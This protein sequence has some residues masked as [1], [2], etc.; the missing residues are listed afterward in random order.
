MHVNKIRNNFL[1]FRA[2]I[3]KD[4]SETQEKQTSTN[5]K[6]LLSLAAL[7]TIG[8]SVVGAKKTAKI[9]F[10]EALKNNGVEIKNGIAILIESGE[11][12]TGKIQRFE[13]GNRKETVEYTDGL[14]K[15]KVY[16]NLFGREL[17][18]EFYR[19]GVLKVR[20]NPYVI[21]DGE[22]TFA[23][24]DNGGKFKDCKTMIAQTKASVFDWARNRASSCKW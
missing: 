15:E 18:G 24:Y 2:K 1:L 10:E 23:Y 17:N 4:A 8:L 14:I 11:K 16:H 5:S 3:S 13:T 6:L 7:A 9:S 20:V 22:K 19:D 21:K 12:F